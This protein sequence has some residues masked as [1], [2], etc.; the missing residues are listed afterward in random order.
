[1]C[2]FLFQINSKLP[3]DTT[4]FSNQLNLLKWRG[5]DHQKIIFLNHKRIGLMH[6][7]LSIQDLKSHAHQP[8]SSQNDRYFILFNGEIYNHFDL[9]KKLKLNCKTNSDTET[10]IEGYS[11]VGKKIFEMLD[12][13]FAIVILDKLNNN[14]I[15]ARDSFGI[16]PMYLYQDDITTIISSETHI[17]SSLI[18]AKICDFS[19]K[20]L[21]L[22]RRPI[23][24]KTIYKNIYEVLPGTI[25]TSSGNRTKIWDWEQKNESFDQNFLEDLIQKSIQK[26]L[27][28]DVKV[29]SLLSGGIDSAIIS[30]QSKIQKSYT[31]GLFRNN[32]FKQTQITADKL[33][34]DLRQIKISK[35][36]LFNAW[37]YLVNL[38][39]EPLNLPNEGLLYLVFKSFEKQEKVALT[40]E[41]ADEIFFGYDRIFRM[42]N[43]DKNMNINKLMK[44]Y[45][46]DNSNHT[47]RMKDYLFDLSRGK[48]LIN[49]LEDFFYQ[50]HLPTL[51]RRMDFAS[52]ASSKEA[53]VPFVDKSIISYLY[54]LPSFIKINNKEAKIPLREIVKKFNLFNVLDKN[55]IGFNSRVNLKDDRL[56]E[57][58][59]F[60]NFQFKELGWNK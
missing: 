28:S 13:M 25:L 40:G 30:S 51:L 4:K 58:K 35:S 14:W 17:V 8:M 59:K 21:R 5:P 22:L 15:A 19:L 49:F 45:M 6:C 9:R 39:N 57:Y 11:K 23:P 10:I 31:V 52:M 47:E 7:R 33:K 3:I 1:M 29:V 43:F 60:Y 50:H 54:R 53:R 36:S 42:A 46:Y 16:K 12:G 37:K 24:G 18:D 20:E 48:S 32:E 34:I 56:N 38:R 2:G 44:A 26:H 55:K 41:G 27:I